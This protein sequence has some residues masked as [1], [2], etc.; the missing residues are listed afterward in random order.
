MGC[1]FTLSHMSIYSAFPRACHE[2]HQ[3]RLG[4]PK[5]SPPS[6]RPTGEKGHVWPL[7][8]GCPV[9][10]KGRQAAA[11]SQQQSRQRPGVGTGHQISGEPGY[12]LQ[13]GGGAGLRRPMRIPNCPPPSGP[14]KHP[15]TRT[16]EPG[17]QSGGSPVP[18]H[19]S[20]HSGSFSVHPKRQG[21][22]DADHD[23]RHHFSTSLTRSQRQE[24]RFSR[25]TH[26]T[27]VLSA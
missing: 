22:R 12:V 27:S 6:A 8:S 25:S 16:P 3:Q 20:V 5:L 26:L 21:D 7:K 17:V 13:S 23:L 14:Q 1:L 15:A 24:R 19:H 10:K 9:P 2:G 18:A 4:C 11:H